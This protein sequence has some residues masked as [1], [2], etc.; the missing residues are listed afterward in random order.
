MHADRSSGTQSS[1][2]VLSFKQPSS[3]QPLLTKKWRV[4]NLSGTT[5][6]DCS[7]RR[8]GGKSC[9]RNCLRLDNED[10][11]YLFSDI[12]DSFKHYI[13]M[14]DSINLKHINRYPPSERHAPSYENRLP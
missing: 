12:K 8:E 11:D 9:D 6:S 14:M 3:Q 10:I 13:S 4:K 1:P 5:I 2:H 7:A